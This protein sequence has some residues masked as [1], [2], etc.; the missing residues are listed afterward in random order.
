MRSRDLPHNYGVHAS[1][2]FLE[3]GDCHLQETGHELVL[4]SRTKEVDDWTLKFQKTDGVGARLAQ[5]EVI[6]S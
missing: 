5:W 4:I 6:N 1:A 2:A 3:P